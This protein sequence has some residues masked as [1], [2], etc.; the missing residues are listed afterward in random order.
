M[1]YIGSPPQFAQF[2]SKFFDGDGSAMTVTLDYAPPNLAALLVFISGVRQDTSAYTLSGTSLTFTGTVPSGTANVQVVHLGQLAEIPTPGDDTVSA[3]KLQSDSVIT[4]KILDDNVTTAKILD[5]NVTLAKLDDGTQGDILYYGASGAPARLGFGTSGDFLKTQGTG[6]NPVWG[7]VTEYNDAAV[8]NDIATLA[9]HSAVQNN[10]A[11]YNLSNA[12][13]D[14]YEDSTGIDVLTDAVR[15]SGEYMTSI[16]PGVLQSTMTVDRGG[17]NSVTIL[18]DTGVNNSGTGN[19]AGQV[20]EYNFTLGTQDARTRFYRINTSGVEQDANYHG[21]M[22]AVSDD[23]DLN[24]TD[25]N[26]AQSALNWFGTVNSTGERDSLTDAATVSRGL[27]VST[28]NGGTT[29]FGN[30]TLDLSSSG[31]IVTWYQNGSLGSDT[32]YGAEVFYDAS[33]NTIKIYFGE[34]G[35]GTGGVFDATTATSASLT[36]TNVPTSGKYY[37]GYGQAAGGAGN[38]VGIDVS[39]QTLDSTNGVLALDNA[40]GNY[41]STTE[42]ASATVSEMGIVVLYKNAYGTAALN[43]D[44]IAAIS[45]DGGS[46][47]TT[48]TLTAAGTF[49]TG[50]NIA[51][52]NGVTISNTGTAP[53]YKISFA[54]QAIASKETQ[55]Y[56]VAMLY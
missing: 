37:L 34:S 21:V 32:A 16:I 15:A 53:K 22:V 51:V 20:M 3:A 9:L 52:A 35:V 2:P 45:A 6:A 5:N 40:T 27:G 26:N 25:W 44:L 47:Y 10:Q 12:F 18:T 24:Y 38:C 19:Y 14:Q 33:A 39:T 11:A 17:T 7:T 8:L 36:L 41:T 43:T 23:S 42:T 50:I 28:Y 29:S 48:T 55:I 49:S 54:N 46:N 30:Q 13:V 31:K 4:A 1:S 56:G